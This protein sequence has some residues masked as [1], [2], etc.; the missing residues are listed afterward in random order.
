VYFAVANEVIEHFKN[1]A[2]LDVGYRTFA[3]S[4]DEL[5]SQ[6]IFDIAHGAILAF[7]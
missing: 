3:P 2:P 1:V 5:A 6:A 7:A 4:R